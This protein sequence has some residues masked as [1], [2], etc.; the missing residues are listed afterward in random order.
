LTARPLTEPSS[1]LATTPAP[2]PTTHQQ[3]PPSP[4]QHHENQKATEVCMD[5]EA[6]CHIWCMLHKI[7]GLPAVANSPACLNGLHELLNNWG[8]SIDQ[9]S[10][11]SWCGCHG[12]PS[13]EMEPASLAN[14]IINCHGELLQAIGW[15]Y[16]ESDL[17][18][19]LTPGTSFNV[20]QGTW[21]PETKRRRRQG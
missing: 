21:E 17:V 18:Q 11:V 12:T 9:W 20:S 3:P 16:D 6:A 5:C 7:M 13:C 19:L 10:R 15:H 1:N 14:H 4:K 2:K 8:G